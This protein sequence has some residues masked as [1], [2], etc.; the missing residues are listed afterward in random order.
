MYL[1]FRFLFILVFLCLR[2]YNCILIFG[3]FLIFF[4][5]QRLVK[6][7]LNISFR[8]SIFF[9]IITAIM[10]DIIFYLN[11]HIWIIT[12]NF[13]ILP[14]SSRW[15]RIFLN[16]SITFVFHELNLSIL[17]TCI[18]FLIN[19]LNLK[20][21]DR[22]LISVHNNSVFH[23][24]DIRNALDFFHTLLIHSK[25]RNRTMSLCFLLNASLI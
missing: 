3:L 4:I 8:K 12:F 15:Y 11:M 22:K 1:K 13:F 14:K 19:L 25:R 20:I 9:L 10:I 16:F 24:L 7:F 18:D 17:L 2:I 23:L 21:I 5:L 6:L